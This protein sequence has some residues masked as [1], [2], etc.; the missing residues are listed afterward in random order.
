VHARD[1]KAGDQPIALLPEGTSHNGRALL[2]FFTGAFAPGVPVQLCCVTS[3]GP[4]R[5]FCSP[6]RGDRPAGTRTATSTRRRSA[7]RCRRTSGG[8]SSVCT[9]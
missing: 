8:P 1:F 2:V 5:I 9:R 7:G 3:A 4:R 6:S